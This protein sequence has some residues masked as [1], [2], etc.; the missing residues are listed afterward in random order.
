MEPEGNLPQGHTTGP[1]GG[2]EPT[3]LL[4]PPPPPAPLVL[5]PQHY[6]LVPFQQLWGAGAHHQPSSGNEQENEKNGP[7]GDHYMVAEENTDL[8]PMEEGSDLYN[9]SVNPDQSAHA[10]LQNELE[11]L[12][13]LFLVGARRL[14]D[15]EALVEEEFKKVREWQEQLM[16]YLLG[17]AHTVAR[18]Q[19]YIEQMGSRLSSTSTY[20]EQASTHLHEAQVAQNALMMERTEQLGAFVND[21]AMKVSNL[22]PTFQVDEAD[23]RHVQTLLGAAASYS[24]RE[25]HIRQARMDLR[26]KDGREL[27]EMGELELPY[28]TPM[29]RLYDHRM[30]ML[31]KRSR[32][33]ET[34]LEMVVQE[35]RASNHRMEVLAARV[36]ELEASKGTSSKEGTPACDNLTGLQKMGELEGRVLH[37][38][39]DMKN[40]CERMDENERKSFSQRMET[41]EH[42]QVIET[43]RHRQVALEEDHDRLGEEMRTLRSTHEV[44]I[45]EHGELEERVQEQARSQLHFQDLQEAH[46]STLRSTLDAGLDVKRERLDR[47]EDREA[48]RRAQARSHEK[49]VVELNQ[50]HTQTIGRMESELK[51]A[52]QILEDEN[53]QRQGTIDDLRNKIQELDTAAHEQREAL[54]DSL[55]H[56]QVEFEKGMEKV[57]RM[58]TGFT[59]ME[60]ISEST[61]SHESR[62]SKIRSRQASL[63]DEEQEEFEENDLIHKKKK[64]RRGE[65]PARDGTSSEDSYVS[66]PRVIYTSTTAG[67]GKGKERSQDTIN[68]VGSDSKGRSSTTSPYV[69]LGD[70]RVGE[71]L[72]QIIPQPKFSG[73]PSDWFVFTHD[74]RRWWKYVE[75]SC[76]SKDGPEKGDIFIASMNSQ[77]KHYFTNMVRFHDWTFE[78]MWEHCNDMHG[79]LHN[80]NEVLNEWQKMKMQKVGTGE[81]ASQE[82]LNWYYSWLATLARVDKTLVTKEIVFQQYL[83]GL[84]TDL[85]KKVVGENQKA[86]TERGR[87]ITL[88]EAHTFLMKRLTKLDQVQEI[89][90]QVQREQEA[91]KTKVN[92]VATRRESRGDRYTRTAHASRSDYHSKGHSEGMIDQGRRKRTP[93]SRPNEGTPRPHRSPFRRDG[94]QSPPHQYP[95][96]RSSSQEGSHSYKGKVRFQDGAK[97]NSPQPTTARRSPHAGGQGSGAGYYWDAK[98]DQGN[99]RKG[100]DHPATNSKAAGPEAQGNPR[101]YSSG[102]PPPPPLSRKSTYY[103]P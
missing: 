93:P 44:Y 16:N 46:N 55:R 69:L 14:A 39:D 57:R 23:W 97:R 12:R 99:G 25:N 6:R 96:R 77:L 54:I 89:S 1:Q 2:C 22:T 10:G 70:R 68:S 74:W 34:T 4:T 48:I 11:Q 71:I 103:R 29:E 5:V 79:T 101:R 40:V 92:A 9:N 100:T 59:A 83:K 61:P 76:A 94:T 42:R 21:L 85:M 38:E 82:Y 86:Q 26:E 30:S 95:R 18:Q 50:H 37:L 35:M 53:Q 66:S 72:S 32:R 51:R 49:K 60:I 80:P 24:E 33:Q 84:S 43:L 62:S 8:V 64:P 90:K 3:Q 75:R 19:R 91:G 36:K 52:Q 58:E 63:E 28:L 98:G 13:Q 7:P 102:V 41:V 81:S 88:T 67:Q 20:V 87:P 15:D 31:G 78:Q 17:E 65:S 56:Q 27:D 45:R 47:L 73:R